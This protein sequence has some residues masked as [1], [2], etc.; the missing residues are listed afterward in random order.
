M[1]PTTATRGAVYAVRDPRAVAVSFANHRG[2]DI[3]DTI[4]RMEDRE[5]GSSGSIPRLSQQLFER[6]RH[7]SDHV[8]RG[9][10]HRFR[11]ILCVMRTCTTIRAC[12]RGGA[13][14]PVA[15]RQRTYRG[16]GRGGGISP[17]ASPGGRA[18]GIRKPSRSPVFFRRR[19]RRRLAA[20]SDCGA[21]KAYR[22]RARRRRTAMQLETR[23]FYHSRP[24]FGSMASD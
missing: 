9:W 14:S 15:L 8:G 17:P 2:R 12:C 13:I 24:S 18:A 16:R 7:W 20:G 4:D 3:D 10:A 22:D 11:C 23:S 5:A 6:P 1:F 21:G 19:S